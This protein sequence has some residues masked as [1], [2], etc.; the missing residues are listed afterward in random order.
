[1]THE[2]IAE[3]LQL[4]LLGWLGA[5]AAIVFVKML[6]GGINVTGLMCSAKGPKADP[7]R[8]TLV[9]LTVGVALYYLVHSIGI[10]LEELKGADGKY[11]MPD[12]PGDA[13][14]LLGGSQTAY[15]TGKI[16][17]PKTGV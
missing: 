4:F 3:F 16:F 1:M 12:L 10:P 6:S 15:I 7:E 2:N 5:L 8:V 13:L 11:S 9:M 14:I 17:R